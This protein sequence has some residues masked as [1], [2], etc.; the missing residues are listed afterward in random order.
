MRHSIVDDPAAERALPLALVLSLDLLDGQEAVLVL[1]VIWWARGS[2]LNSGIWRA[3]ILLGS[4]IKGS[5]KLGCKT[6]VVGV[7]WF[8]KIGSCWLVPYSYGVS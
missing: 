7:W 4:I 2:F 6:E 5:P 1:V 8:G 3:K